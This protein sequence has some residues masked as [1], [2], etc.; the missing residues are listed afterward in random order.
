MPMQQNIKLL[1][2]NAF[3]Y[4]PSSFTFGLLTVLPYFFSASKY[5]FLLAFPF[6]HSFHS[7]HFSLT[8]L[9]TP[10]FL[11]HVCL[12]IAGFFVHPQLLSVVSSKASFKTFQQP[13]TKASFWLL[14]LY[15]LMY[16]LKSFFRLPLYSFQIF[17]L[18]TNFLSPVILKSHTNSLCW[19]IHYS[20]S[21]TFKSLKNLFW[22]LL[23]K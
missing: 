20:W 9:Q 14:V 2:P 13:S 15:L 4:F 1:S 22:F 7:S 17:F 11:H 23:A 10:L 3:K 18:V 5:F 6:F 16:N 12:C 19:V 21:K 8:P